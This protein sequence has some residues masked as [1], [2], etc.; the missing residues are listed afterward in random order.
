MRLVIVTLAGQ[1]PRGQDMAARR[2]RTTHMMTKYSQYFVHGTRMQ[3]AALHLAGVD[4]GRRLA[5]DLL[6]RRHV[7]KL[8][9]A[10]A[11]TQL[12]AIADVAAQAHLDHNGLAL[13][14]VMQAQRFNGRVQLY[15][16]G[17][18]CPQRVWRAVTKYTV[19]AMFPSWS[20]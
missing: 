17:F 16:Q 7:D 11:Q 8:I 3:R 10:A 12:F 4:V 20:M 6:Q 13:D 1:V 9:G 19:L 18:L 2:Y 15:R 14:A 5:L